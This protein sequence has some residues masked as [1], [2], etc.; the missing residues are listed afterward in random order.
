MLAKLLTSFLFF[1]SSGGILLAADPVVIDFEDED[2]DAWEF[3]DELPENLGDLGPSTWDIFD[4][5]LGFDS[6]VL[7]Q[8]SNIWGG[9]NDH[10]LM[11]T[12]AYY[13]VRE[14]ENFRLEVDVIADDNDGMGF[15]W[16]YQEDTERH[17]RFQLMNDRWP[18]VPSLDGFNGP[19]LIAHKRISDSSPWYEVME[20][21]EADEY[22]PYSQGFG[23]VN[24][25]TLEVIDG[26]FTITTVDSFGDENTLS[27]F[28]DEF[29]SGYVGIQLYAQSNV[30]FDNFVITPLDDSVEGDFNGNDA[31]DAEDIDLLTQAVLGGNHPAEFDLNG[32]QLVNNV[33]RVRW[34][35]D[36]FETHL[37][38]SN[39]DGVFDSGDLVDVFGAGKYVVDPDMAET[40]TW[41]EGDWNGDTLFD[42][43]DLVLA[44]QDSGYVAGSAPAVPEPTS[45]AMLIAGVI[46]LARV[47]RTRRSRI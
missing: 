3:V 16:G 14:F 32:D 1:M 41:A 42:S 39:L 8:G 40:A 27:G 7:S 22:I 26:A 11:G 29:K 2:F 38:D 17:Y 34:V 21:L 5:F 15:V 23:E 37:G 25:W 24:H 4:S 6:I 46:G 10:M 47:S 36:L 18:E 35:H 45:L 44:F 33:D 13:N 20:V 19:Y 30:E 28:D 43:G 31:L 9:P 12:I